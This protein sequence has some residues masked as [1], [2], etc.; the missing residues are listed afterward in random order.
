MLE[1]IKGHVIELVQA[2]PFAPIYVKPAVK[3]AVT[4]EL[5]EDEIH[6]D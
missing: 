2:E 4:D 1:L 6:Y 5:A 3:A